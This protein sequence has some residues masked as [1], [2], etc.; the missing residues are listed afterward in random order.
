MYVCLTLACR[1]VL[2]ICRGFKDGRTAELMLARAK[3]LKYNDQKKKKLSQLGNPGST[4][5]RLLVR[6]S[7]E[8]VPSG[9]CIPL[10]VLACR[11]NSHVV[12]PQ[13]STFIISLSSYK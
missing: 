3:K 10:S 12:N 2:P 8:V 7:G 9:G 4:V 13:M 5:N 11:R 1:I 6:G